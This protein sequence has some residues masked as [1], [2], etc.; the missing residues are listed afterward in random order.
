M[1]RRKIICRHRELALSREESTATPITLLLEFRGGGTGGICL[2]TLNISTAPAFVGTSK[3]GHAFYFLYASC[4]IVSIETFVTNPLLLFLII[5][6]NFRKGEHA[7]T[8]KTHLDEV[9]GFLTKVD[10]I[11]GGMAAKSMPGDTSSDSTSKKKSS[12][13]KKRKNNAKES[14]D[15]PSKKKSNVGSNGSMTLSQR[16][17]RALDLLASYLEERGG[18]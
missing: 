18:M 10:P 3:M 12:T 1:R 15:A 4:I 7:S 17:K 2:G 6:Y 13:A 11:L 16:E 14:P 5:L 8:A 9:V